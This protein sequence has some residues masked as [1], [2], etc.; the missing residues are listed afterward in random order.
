[1]AS[2]AFVYCLGVGALTVLDVVFISHVLHRRPETVGV[3]YL[4]NGAGAFVGSTLMLVAGSRLARH[5]HHFVR[6]PVLANGGALLA[7]ALAPSLRVAVV[8]VG[9]V[10][11]FF[12][13]A[14]VS[15]LTLIQL[16]AEDRV[17]GRVMSLCNM[18]IA[19]GLLISLAWGGALAD[20]L[21]VRQVMGTGAVI[22]ALCG[23]LNALLVRETPAPPGPDVAH[24][25]EVAPVTA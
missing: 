24:F 9:A 1:L 23:V 25:T 12:S 17:M 2:T 8:A 3:L 22:I 11:F 10:G 13:I 16:S 21:G 15:F 6:W 14:L 19:A 4:A 5:Y 7:Y 20:L 18:T